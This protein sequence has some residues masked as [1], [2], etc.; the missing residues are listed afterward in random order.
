[1]KEVTNMGNSKINVVIVDNNKDFCIILN[2]YLSMQKDI[3]VTGIAANGIEALK[4][5]EE[6]KPNLVILNIIMPVLDGLGV[7]EK[8]NTMDITPLPRIIILSSIAQNKIIK[9]AML[10]GSDCYIIKPF[11]MELFVK[12]IREI[13]YEYSFQ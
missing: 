6:K 3:I 2:D 11:D 5:I 12:R 13:K 9:K 8:L 7:L 1:M 10:L 4:L